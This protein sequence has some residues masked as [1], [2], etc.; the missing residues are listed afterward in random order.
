MHLTE[1]SEGNDP[2]LDSEIPLIRQIVSKEVAQLA[3]LY[4]QMCSLEDV[5]TELVAK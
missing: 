4:A 2:S 5:P 1:A 3:A